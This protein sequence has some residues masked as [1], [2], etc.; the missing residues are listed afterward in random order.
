MSEIL[1]RLSGPNGLS[2]INISLESTM[3]DLY[4]KINEKTHISADNLLLSLDN[5]QFTQFS[6]EIKLSSIKEFEDGVKLFVKPN[7]KEERIEEEKPPS[8][9]NI[10]LNESSITE[11]CTHGPN[12]KCLNCISKPDK[13]DKADKEDDEKEKYIR[14]E[15]KKCN[16]GPHA[17]C[18][19]CMT[20]EQKDVKHLSFDEF[21][22]KNYAKCKNHSKHQKCTNCFVDLEQSYKVKKDCK[23]HEPYPKGMCSKCIPPLVTVNR[24]EYRHVDFASFMNYK[25]ISNLIH[26]WMD[27]LNQRVAYVYGYY[28][29][30][31]VYNKGVRAVVEA[32]Y[33]PPQESNFNNSIIMDDPFEVHVDMITSTLGLERVGWLFT[34]FDKESFLTSEQIIQAAKYQEMFKVKHPIG[35]DVSKQITIVLRCDA[36]KNNQVAPEVYMISDQCQSLVRDQLIDQPDNPKT[37]RIKQAKDHS[38]NTNFLYQGK[39]V[40]EIEPDFF[41]VNVAHGQPKNTLHNILDNTDFQVANRDWPQTPSDLMKYMNSRRHLKSYERYANLHVLLFLA[42]MLD[43][44]TAIA[45]AEC[46][47]DRVE[48][49]EYLEMLIESHLM[50]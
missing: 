4:K 41:I 18:L 22:D 44:H 45:V 43:I 33:E 17:K 25:E 14:K 39:T 31:P 28:A 13:E 3:S 19:N 8:Q 27:N 49:P 46:V 2:R 40:D 50:H 5:V 23:E 11:K 37:L 6:P 26:Y 1:I 38:F 42:K 36:A 10:P 7:I 15:S 16:H 20:N 9:M 48:V 24:Q 47:R 12:G 32:L 30:D 34:T 35:L 21:V 29:E